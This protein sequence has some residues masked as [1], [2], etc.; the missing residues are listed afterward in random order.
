MT[1]VESKLQCQ[2]ETE[3]L[4]QETFYVKYVLDYFK[5]GADI[6]TSFLR[7]AYQMLFVLNGSA[8]IVL[9]SLA[10]SIIQSGQARG[11]EMLDG[12]VNVAVFF[13]LGGAF[14]LASAVV[15][16]ARAYIIT[17]SIV[18]QGMSEDLR[19]NTDVVDRIWCLIQAVYGPWYLRLFLW[20]AYV[21]LALSMGVFAYALWRSQ[22][23][24]APL[25]EHAS[26]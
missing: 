22:S 4:G 6:V 26:P 2:I 10:G 8:V 11:Q 20:L 3:K 14:S 15:V 21:F 19:R 12:I 25:I 5:M 17:T 24:W 16:Y 18:R 7:S 9:L 13:A 1:D 23:I